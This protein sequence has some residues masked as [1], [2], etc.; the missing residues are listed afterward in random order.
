MDSEPSENRSDG[1]LLLEQF[2]VHGRLRR[3]DHDDVS[4]LEV[5]QEDVERAGLA[6]AMP[7]REDQRGEVV[8]DPERAAAAQV[9]HERLHPL[10]ELAEPHLARE[11][12]VRSRFED[13]PPLIVQA[14]RDEA[15]QDS[16][17]DSRLADEEHRA[18]PFAAERRLELANRRLD[19][20]VR[21]DVVDGEVLLLPDVADGAEPRNVDARARRELDDLA[22]RFGVLRIEY[23]ERVPDLLGRA[24]AEVRR[25]EDLAAVETEP[26]ELAQELRRVAVA[27]SPLRADA[28]EDVEDQRVGG[29]RQRVQCPHREVAAPRSTDR[30][31]ALEEHRADCVRVFLSQ[32]QRFESQRREDAAVTSRVVD[33][34]LVRVLGV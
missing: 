28:P 31:Q 16:L 15:G 4:R 10:L 23:A 18:P 26:D 9:L 33:E 3:P 29:R 6:V 13:R 14:L 8:D 17:A 22:Q 1:R 7:S 24:C 20:T 34:L 21:D 27:L 25:L 11:Q 2:V 30:A 5:R 12:L 19:R 32:G